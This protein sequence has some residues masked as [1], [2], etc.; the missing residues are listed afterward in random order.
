M[1]YTNA[2]FLILVSLLSFIEPFDA[3]LKTNPFR[4]MIQRRVSIPVCSQKR[5]YYWTKSDIHILQFLR[6][7]GATWRIIST[8]LNRSERACMQRFYDIMKSDQW[9]NGDQKKLLQSVSVFGENWPEV[10][11]HLKKLEFTEDVILSEDSCRLQYMQHLR[12]QFVVGM[13]TS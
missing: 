4:S 13:S 5:I 2:F 8:T 12:Q 7:K 10:T 6:K 3:L 9:S 11:A 1:R